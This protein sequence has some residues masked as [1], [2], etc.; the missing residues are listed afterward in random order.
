MGF[1]FVAIFAL[2]A[3]FDRPIPRGRPNPKTPA[4]DNAG[5]QGV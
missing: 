1:I 2:I 3:A 5:T 4:A